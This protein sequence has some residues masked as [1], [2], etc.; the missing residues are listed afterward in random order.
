MRGDLSSN[1]M[2]LNSGFSESELRKQGLVTVGILFLT[3]M[4]MVGG[5]MWC[6]ADGARE[7]AELGMRPSYAANPQSG[8]ATKGLG[9]SEGKIQ[10][11]AGE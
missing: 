7:R 6:S 2:V 8:A 11:S 4:L 1:S 3:A 10:T 9:D 5:A